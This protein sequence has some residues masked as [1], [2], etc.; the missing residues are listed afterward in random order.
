MWMRKKAF[1]PSQHPIK[2]EEQKVR[3]KRERDD[4]MMMERSDFT[5]QVIKENPMEEAYQE[6][7]R[8]RETERK[9]EREKEK[10]KERL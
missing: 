10:E 2:E 6:A 9:R 7:R 1:T 3:Q 8:E 4:H 5:L